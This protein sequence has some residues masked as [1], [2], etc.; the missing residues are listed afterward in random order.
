M[1]LRPM[2]NPPDLFTAS[3]LRSWL[4]GC[5]EPPSLLREL[6]I[7][8][9]RPGYARPRPEPVLLPGRFLHSTPELA[10]GGVGSTGEAERRCGSACKPLPVSAGP[11]GYNR[12]NR[13]Y[14]AAARQR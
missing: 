12:F 11:D 10:A 6:A 5:P 7:S 4:A 8:P 1:N 13:G 2:T 3:F 9:A 14:V